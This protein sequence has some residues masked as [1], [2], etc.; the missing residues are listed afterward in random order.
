MDTSS[1]RWP[2]T[3]RVREGSRSWV[4]ATGGI[5]RLDSNDERLSDGDHPQE[6]VDQ[7]TGPR[8]RRIVVRRLAGL[9][10]RPG[11]LLDEALALFADLQGKEPRILVRDRTLV[12]IAM[13]VMA[14]GQ[15]LGWIRIGVG[16]S[17]TAA[18]LAAITTSG[19]GKKRWVSN[20]RPAGGMDMMYKSSRLASS[21]ASTALA[22]TASEGVALRY[23]VA[24]PGTYAFPLQRR[25]LQPGSRSVRPGV[26]QGDTRDWSWG[27]PQGCADWDTW[28]YGLDDLAGTPRAVRAA[29]ACAREERSSS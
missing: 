19:L 10:V 14:N 5:R 27:M 11:R 17:A 20:A 4:E 7:A 18:K 24:N 26:G 25:K 2:A 16:Q 3:N 21:R 13:P 15:R 8:L 29:C 28:G 12:D 22:S 1:R 9:Q 6:P 23:V